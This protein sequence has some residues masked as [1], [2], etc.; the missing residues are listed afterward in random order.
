MN[1]R[2]NY[3]NR[4]LNDGSRWNPGTGE[5]GRDLRVAGSAAASRAVLGWDGP[6]VSDP[7][8]PDRLYTH[9]HCAFVCPPC[10]DDTGDSSESGADR[11]VIVSHHV[12]DGTD[13]GRDWTESRD[14]L[15]GRTDFSPTG[16]RRRM[17]R[18]ARVHDASYAPAGY[19]AVH[20]SF[21]ERTG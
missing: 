16:S 12:R 2:N 5:F 13:A 15:D 9:H 20:S 14:S 7:R 6:A 8:Q 18:I 11:T 10:S 1:S 4:V 21:Q 19:G 17:G 3:I